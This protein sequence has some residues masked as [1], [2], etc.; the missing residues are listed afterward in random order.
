[1]VKV[2]KKDCF[3]V[4]CRREWYLAHHPVSHSHKP[5]KVQHV[6]NG[7]ANS[8]GS[9]LNDALLNRVNFIQKLIH[10]LIRF[11]QNQYTV[12]A[13]IEGM[14]LQVGVIPQDQPS[15]CFFVVDGP[16]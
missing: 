5:G 4:D 15:H 2:D 7:A 6:L 11:R 10:V 1:M 16:S 3:K 9:S 12:S 8:H 13:D 14:F